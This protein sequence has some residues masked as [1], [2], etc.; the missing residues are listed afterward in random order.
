MAFFVNEVVDRLARQTLRVGRS[1]KALPI[2]G[3][4]WPDFADASGLRVG[5]ELVATLLPERP[6]EKAPDPG[7]HALFRALATVFRAPKSSCHRRK[8]ATRATKGAR[9]CQMA[10]P[11]AGEAVCHCQRASTAADNP[12]CH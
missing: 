11:R 5:H 6:A 10:L 8:G 7:G 2:P 12:S 4:A 1:G 3:A 9:H